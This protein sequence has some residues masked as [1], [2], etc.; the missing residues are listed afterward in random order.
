MS[1]IVETKTNFKYLIGYLDKAIRPLVL[2]VPKMSGHVQTFKVKDGDKNEN[3]LMS[4]HIDDE[5]FLEKHKTIW[6]KIEVLK[7]IEWNALP[8]YDDRYIKANI[9]TYSNKVYTN[10]C[11]LNV[12]EDD[13]ECES[14]TVIFIDSLLVYNNKYYLQVYL[15]NCVFI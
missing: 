2:M 10:F 7:N 8:V 11:G 13:V 15:D 14:F 6:I 12:P 1:K 4:F 5:N 3:K 9:R